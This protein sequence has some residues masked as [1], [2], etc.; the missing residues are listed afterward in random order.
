V[1]P[2]FRGSVVLFTKPS[3]A[4]RVKT[5]LSPEM[6]PEQAGLIHAALVN[7]TVVELARGEFDLVVAWDLQGD[8]TPDLALL[9]G[10][11]DSDTERIQHVE[12]EGS[13]LGARLFAGLTA[14]L[15]QHG[16][17]GAPAVAA[18]G[19][20]HPEID[21][22]EVEAAFAEIEAGRA[23]VVVGPVV[24]GGYYL[25]A[26]GAP[27]LKRRL[28]EDIEWSSSSVS[29]TTLARCAELGLEV[30]ELRSSRD[31]DT[32]RDL[33]DL[34]ARVHSGEARL[35]RELERLL[36]SWGML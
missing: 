31:L 7:D 33:R 32:A 29:A 36:A 9:G 22:R 14:A 16:R 28:F 10:L 27:A 8:E 19:S 12:Q 6:S 21:H 5:R 35:H 26:M 30:V 20:D 1:T 25:I 15:G 34:V 17:R 3:V 24:D 4:G 2:P 13:D 23:D 11:T 18:V